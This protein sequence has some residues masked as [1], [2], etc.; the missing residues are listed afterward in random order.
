MKLDISPETHANGKLR[1]NIR[2]TVWFKAETVRADGAGYISWE[3]LLEFMRFF[4]GKPVHKRANSSSFPYKLMNI[5]KIF[6]KQ[7]IFIEK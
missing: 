4:E 5:F 1:S 7:L 3:I 2:A 6:A